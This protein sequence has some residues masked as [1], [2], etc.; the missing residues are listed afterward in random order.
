MRGN[1]FKL[2]R[3]RFRL[4]TKKKYFTM[5]MVRHLHGLLRDVVDPPSLEVSKAR[6]DQALGNLWCTAGELDQ[7][8]FKG[9]FQL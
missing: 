3:G 9:S 6:L 4:D 8:T 1:V 5:R 2:R 7:M